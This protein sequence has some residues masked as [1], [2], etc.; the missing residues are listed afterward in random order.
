MKIAMMVSDYPSEQ[1]TIPNIFVHNII[2]GLHR[3][4]IEA[5]V[6]LMDFRSI[7]KKR[8]HGL[9]TYNYDGVN[10]YRLSFPCGP[11]HGLL[12]KLM[13]ASANKLYKYAV[14][15]EGAPD[16]IHAHFGAMAFVAEG[17]SKKYS[18]PLVLTEHLSSLMNEGFIRSRRSNYYKKGYKA[19]NSIVAVST[20]LANVIS[21]ITKRDISVIP[22]VLS[23]A[24]FNTETEKEQ[25]F[26]AIT[27][28][29]LE[30]RKRID[31]VIDAV[32]DLKR[33][34]NQIKLWIVGDGSMRSELEHKVKELDL[35]DQIKFFG[36]QNHAELN[37]LYN[38]SHVFVLTSDAETFGVVYIE[39]NAC[40]IPII[41]TDCG[42]P[43]D[44]VTHE[45][46]LLIQR[47]SVSDV[48]EALKYIMEHYERYD[49][50]EISERA[51]ELYGETA[52]IARYMNLYRGLINE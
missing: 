34:G 11:I 42:G 5:F 7:R 20:P 23:S 31:L 44:I 32:Y 30:S 36:K 37:V 25:E 2:K 47:N 24:F 40:G 3:Q 38:K 29:A 10:V 14:E 33:S 4:G 28:G 48:T 46:G 15:R 49:P 41:A 12:E 19:S 16:I 9:S 50:K 17:I 51:V 8:K 52:V 18:I 6:L 26:T 22:N 43:S 39:A 1:N 45:N 21:D 13:R 27:V 35:S